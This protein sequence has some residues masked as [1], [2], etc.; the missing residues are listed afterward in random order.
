MQFLLHHGRW[1]LTG[2]A[3]AAALLA[4]LIVQRALR[5]LSSETIW[6]CLKALGVLL[7][8]IAIFAGLLVVVQYGPEWQLRREGIQIDTKTAQPNADE[9]AKLQDEYRKTILQ[10]LAGV[11]VLAGLWYTRRRILISEQGQ[12]TERYTRA[13]EQLGAVK[14]CG[15]NLYVPNTEVRLGAIYALERIARDSARDHWT[16]MEVLTAYVRENAPA[17]PEEKDK[18]EQTAEKKP[19]TEIQAILTVLGRRQRDKKREHPEQ[20]LDLLGTDLRGADLSSLHFENALFSN[21]QLDGAYFSGAHLDMAAFFNTHLNGTYF[22]GAHL[23]GAYFSGAHLDGAYFLD[24]HLDGANFSMAHLDGAFFLDAHLD[25]AFFLD[26]HLDVANFRAAKSPIVDQILAA[27]SWSSAHFDPE[28][29][30]E[31][32]EAHRKQNEPA[33]DTSSDK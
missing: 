5:R 21:A 3:V 24:A 13:I 9:I 10:A 17:K 28:F 31:L 30:K 25:G 12:I 29:R 26:A 15:E 14:A 18:E 22:S 11:L 4:S 19:A 8:A 6:R 2:I 27:K 7:G 20:C 1:I 32:E 23:D 33:T 16:I